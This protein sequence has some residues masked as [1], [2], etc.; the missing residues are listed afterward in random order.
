MTD[1]VGSFQAEVNEIYE[2]LAGMREAINEIEAAYQ[3]A[4]LYRSQ[5][6]R[7]ADRYDVI[8]NFATHEKGLESRND[9]HFRVIGPLGMPRLKLTKEELTEIV[10]RELEEARENLSKAISDIR[11]IKLATKDILEKV[12]QYKESIRF[13]VPPD[14][15]D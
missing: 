6:K 9:H 5:S 11:N 3:F 14:V 4:S 15:G 7:W 2:A 12:T 8:M 1:D 10:D 13:D